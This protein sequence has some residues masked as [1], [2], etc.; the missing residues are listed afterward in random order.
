MHVGKDIL[1][2]GKDIFHHVE[3]LESAWNE[4]NYLEAGKDIGEIL[5]EILVGHQ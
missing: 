1:V 5:E 2:N 4:K 3:A